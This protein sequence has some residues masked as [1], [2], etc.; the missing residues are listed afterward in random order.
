MAQTADTTPKKK[1]KPREWGEDPVIPVRLT[2]EGRMKLNKRIQ[3]SAKTAEQLEQINENI[4]KAIGSVGTCQGQDC[5]AKAFWVVSP[6]T[7]KKHIYD[8]NGTTHF[9]TCPN[10]DDFR[11]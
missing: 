2:E 3:E 5:E 10:S 6:T 7:K 11:R 9:A 1:E 8:A 4:L